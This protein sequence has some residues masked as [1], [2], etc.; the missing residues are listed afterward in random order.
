MTFG[1]VLIIRPGALGDAI[2]TLPL[3]H[4]LR[5]AGSKRMTV[6]GTP[7]S[8]GFIKTGLENFEIRDFSSSEWLGLFTAENTLGSQKRAWLSQFSAAVVYLA[9]DTASIERAL[10]DAGIPDVICA[11]PPRASMPQTGNR[12]GHTNCHAARCLFEPVSSW[13]TEQC[14]QQALRLNHQ[15]VD[16]LLRLEPPETPPGNED[17]IAIHPGS[18]GRFKCWPVDRFASLATELSGR[19]SMRVKIFFGP[20]DD[21]M[22]AEFASI[23]SPSNVEFIDNLPLRDVFRLLSRAKCY[24]GNDSGMSHLA[25]RACPA[26]VLFGPTDPAIWSPLGRQVRILR[27]PGGRMEDLSVANVLENIVFP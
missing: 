16:E 20:A 4:A 2:L 5:F 24:V 6:L 22:K 9:G 19:R 21:A 12:S 8:W 15:S 14:W 7:A 3:L 27:A 18:G 23:L 1:N 26:L 10:R 13:V 17:F 11:D 25:A